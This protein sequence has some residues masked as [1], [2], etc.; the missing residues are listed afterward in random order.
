MLPNLKTKNKQQTNIKNRGK[1]QIGKHF[2]VVLCNLNHNW[3]DKY[4]LIT[5][6]IHYS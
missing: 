4:V 2:F 3:F 1:Q 5:D 6:K